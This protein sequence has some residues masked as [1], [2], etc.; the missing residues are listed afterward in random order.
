MSLKLHALMRVN[1]IA[2]DSR[3]DGGVSI[4]WVLLNTFRLLIL[5]CM[6]TL[7]SVCLTG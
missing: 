4:S 7:V 2:L 6:T 5:V 3:V 1:F